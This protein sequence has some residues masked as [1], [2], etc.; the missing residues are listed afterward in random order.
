MGFAEDPALHVIGNTC[1]FTLTFV[2][3]CP[4]V[5]P[6]KLA[7]RPRRW[8]HGN[9]S[10][11]SALSQVWFH[12]PRRRHLLEVLVNTLTDTHQRGLNFPR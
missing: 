11:S 7:G 2:Q 6:G 4:G 3:P 1:W 10:Y 12:R 5:S 8:R 9:K